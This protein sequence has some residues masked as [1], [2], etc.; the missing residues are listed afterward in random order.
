MYIDT[1]KQ[2]RQTLQRVKDL[3]DSS[4]GLKGRYVE[5]ARASAIN[6]LARM[7]QDAAHIE[8]TLTEYVQRPVE[9][10]G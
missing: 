6:R 10:K 2:T 4:D 8:Q 3:L 1:I 9:T 5:Q 7:E